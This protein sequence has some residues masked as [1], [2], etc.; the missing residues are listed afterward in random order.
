MA[1][2]QRHL[3]GG[4]VHS[5]VGGVEGGDIVDHADIRKDHLEILRSNDVADQVFDLGHVV[6]GDFDARSGGNFDI[7]GELA[8]IGAAGKTRRPRKG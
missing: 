1:L 8:G 2:I 7:H 5:G 6:V 4:G 3:D